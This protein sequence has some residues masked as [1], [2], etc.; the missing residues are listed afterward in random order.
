[1]SKIQGR[2]IRRALRENG[3]NSDNVIRNGIVLENYA[4]IAYLILRNSRKN[5]VHVGIEKL[6]V[7]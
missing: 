7:F 1:M 4:N 2:F 3:V 5:Y 6:Q